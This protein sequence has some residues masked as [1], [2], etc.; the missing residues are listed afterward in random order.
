MT[1][2]MPAKSCRVGT[3]PRTGAPI[4]VASIGSRASHRITGEDCFLVK[5]H[6][7]TVPDLDQELLDQFLVH[8]QTVTSVVVSAP[9]PP[10]P[11]PLPAPPPA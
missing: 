4:T 8:G 9:V 7:A 5:V 3:W 1:S 10:R 6:A 11:L 2:A